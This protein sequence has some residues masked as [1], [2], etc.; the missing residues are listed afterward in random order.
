MPR[1][2]PAPAGLLAAALGCGLVAVLV[3]GTL[4][5]GADAARYLLLG[6]VALL[7][8]VGCLAVPVEHLPTVALVLL[9]LVPDRIADYSS[10]PVLTPATAVLAVWTVRR[11]LTRSTT[12]AEQPVGGEHRLR[13]VLTGSAVL[14]LVGMVPLVLV[15]P[16][17]RFS[18]GWVATF[19][20]AVVVPLLVGDLEREGRR[21]R[22]ALPWV[23]SVVAGYAIVEYLLEQNL[24]YGPLYDALGLDELQHWSVYRSDA[25]LGHPL[26][27]GLFFA[28]VL[29]FCTGRWLESHRSRFAAAAVL[30]GLGIVTTVSRGSYIAAAAAVSVVLLT[31]LCV[32]RQHRARR[33]LVLAVFAV[34]GVL[35]A[36]SDAFVERGL[37][38][39]GL[40]S[41]NSRSSLPQIAVDTAR[42]YHWLGGG[43]ASS[44]PLAEPYNFQ[45]LP[46][47]N[48]YLQLL[49]GIGLWG[50]ALFVLVLVLAAVRAVRGRSFSGLGALVGYATAAGGFAALDSRRDLVVLLGLLVVIALRRPDE[51]PAPGADEELPRP[52]GR[53][54]PVRRPAA[55]PVGAG[56]GGAR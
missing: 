17:K 52:A 28:T 4:S 27:A 8:L 10:S 54:Q 13:H 37:S 40:S 3:L 7:A 29:G 11:L 19:A 56:R 34:G 53:P 36:N 43:P 31:A 46:I 44:L 35:A 50:L 55:V 16:S 45:H 41:L 51:R 1:L 9:V 47:E 14:L 32:E 38:A 30:N 49:I 18:I 6:V 2:L 24:V 5:G 21:L 39:E 25:T 12:D 20:L 23:G 22:Q 42:A 26:V 48:S 33:L 15:S